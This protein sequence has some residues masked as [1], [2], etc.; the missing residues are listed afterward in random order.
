MEFF[1]YLVFVHITLVVFALIKYYVRLFGDSERESFTKSELT[2][3]TSIIP[4]EILAFL[5]LDGSM[6]Y[7]LIAL[8]VSNLIAYGWTITGGMIGSPH[9]T[10]EIGNYFF[11]S[12]LIFILFLFGY[13]EL[14]ETVFLPGAKSGNP[15][16]KL[17]AQEHSIITGIGLALI[18]SNLAVYGLYHEIYFLFVFFNILIISVLTIYKLCG[19]EVPFLIKSRHRQEEAESEESLYGTNSFSDSLEDEEEELKI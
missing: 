13:P 14:V 4:K 3:F 10:N 16:F 15:L 12:C 9:Y 11:L 17:L 8:L 6:Q 7:S 5:E 1:L 2:S 19:Y 18:G